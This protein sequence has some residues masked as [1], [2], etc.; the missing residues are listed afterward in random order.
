MMQLV[1]GVDD[2]QRW[3]L[4]VDPLKNY[5]ARDIQAI[6][7]KL[8]LASCYEFMTKKDLPDDVKAQRNIFVKATDFSEF[9]EDR[10]NTLMYSMMDVFY[11]F[12]LFQ[13]AYPAY[14]EMANHKAIL[15]GQTIVLDSV[16]PHIEDREDWIER[17]DMEYEKVEQ[18]I[19]DIVFPAIKELHD[20]QINDPDSQLEGLNWDYV[21]PFRHRRDKPLPEGWDIRAKWFEPYRKGNISL[22]SQAIGIL[23]QCQLLFEGEWYDVHFSKDAKFHIIYDDKIVKLPNRKDPGANYGNILS[24]DSLYLVN[25]ETPAL[26]SRLISDSDF[27]NIL[28]LFDVTTTYTGFKKRVVAQNHQDGLVAAEVKPAGTVSGRT[29]SPLYN[30]LPAHWD[31]KFPK[32]MSEIKMTSQCPEG[33]VFVG[34]DADSQE[35]SIAAAMGD[36]FY[37]VSGA[38]PFSRAVVAGNKKDGTDY[39]S[40]TAKNI[41]GKQKVSG[42]ERFGGKPVNFGL[43]YGAG[44]GTTGKTISLYFDVSQNEAYEKARKAV[45]GFKGEKEAYFDAVFGRVEFPWAK[46]EEGIASDVFN[47]MVDMIQSHPPRGLFFNNQWPKALHPVH[48]KTDSSPPQLNYCIQASCSTYGFLSAWITAVYDEIQ[49]NEIEA[50]FSISIHDEIWFI[51][52]RDQAEKLAYWIMICY[53]RTWAL[54]HH[55]L[56][57][58]DMPLVRAFPSSI[59]IDPILRKSPDAETKTPTFPHYPEGEEVTIYDLSKIFPKQSSGSGSR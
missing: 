4:R 3:A 39:H 25:R 19:Y 16:V 54:L 46:Y 17:C 33:W 18:Q 15:A 32:I 34:G 30:T 45:K 56:Y 40:L 55:N 50:R 6:G 22:K 28:R 7:C 43:I 58:E 5:R 9:R 41:T 38:C 20:A 26:R 21:L 11:N 27:L 36:S 2:N 57:I 10:Y 47:K 48:C 51:C 49:R 42:D 59:S 14:Q 29:V 44:V 23:L 1:A 8:G 24:A 37:G 31:P 12:E 35:A 53:A 13:K 52:P